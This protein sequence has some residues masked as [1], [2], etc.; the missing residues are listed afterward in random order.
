M[1]S[2]ASSRR[3]T[4][5]DA[6]VSIDVQ[7]L[8][9]GTQ[10]ANAFTG[11]DSP[12]TAVFSRTGYG[13][14]AKYITVVDEKTFIAKTKGV[15]RD[16]EITF[17][18][19]ICGAYLRWTA[20]GSAIFLE[21]NADTSSYALRI[22]SGV[23]EGRTQSGSDVG[24]GFTGIVKTFTTPAT[25]TISG[26]S[27]SSTSGHTW[28]LG[29]EGFE[30]YLKYNGTEFY[31]VTSLH[32]LT[33][34]KMAIGTH[35]DEATFGVRTVTA[36][37]KTNRTGLYSNIG[38]KIFDIRDF[39]MKAL[40]AT[41]SMTAASTTLTLVSN[42]G[43]AIGD[44]ICIA[45]GG[46][47]GGGIPGERGVGGQWPTLMYANAT[48]R[49][50]D[51]SQVTDKV[52]GLLDTGL[53]YQWN[54]SAWVVY[55][56]GIPR[57]HDKILPK[58]LVATITNVS[59]TNITLDTAAT[60]ST[61]SASVYFDN[62]VLFEDNLDST[63]SG[64][65]LQSGCTIS[66]PAGTWVFAGYTLV[67]GLTPNVRVTGADWDDTIILSP[68]G[69]V[70]TGILVSQCDNAY[71]G[72]M[73]FVG[74]TRTDKGFMFNY[75]ATTD[76]QDGQST[77]F[78]Q[79]LQGN[80]C[81]IEYIR[82]TN[83]SNAVSVIQYSDGS[84]QRFIDVIHETGHKQY[85]Q[86]AVN[87]ADSINCVSEDIT[88]DCPA[89]FKGLESFRSDGSILRRATGRNVIISSN[90]NTNIRIEDCSITYEAG[91]GDFNGNLDLPGGSQ[92]PSPN[93][94]LVNINANIGGESDVIVLENNDFIVE[95]RLWTG[96]GVSVIAI[97]GD[98]TSV[99][100]NGKYQDKPVTDPS[101]RF[102]LPDLGADI[103]SGGS[104]IV[105][106]SMAVVSDVSTV[107]FVVDGVRVESSSSW[108]A[109]GSSNGNLLRANHTV[110]NCVVDATNMP[111]TIS[112]TV[113]NN[114]T[115]AAYE[116]L[117]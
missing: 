99:V 63:E 61:T 3:R 78:V 34:G 62:A 88:F 24:P 70:E 114:I 49:D 101:G 31:R 116:A 25:G 97:I 42:P 106:R 74:N 30:I 94:P 8:T 5:V 47:A 75:N 95:G 39:G 18:G 33:P 55:A 92:N 109:F 20:G 73:A 23:T 113:S 2:S 76:Q 29:V 56:G 11:W 36:T 7:S 77:T 89:L 54:G 1:R 53:T 64:I 68:T 10:S 27:N 87:I 72:N 111:E 37:H 48:A 59:G 98:D 67:F 84:T 100:V 32:V 57:Y 12:A 71:V 115:N 19:S 41:G 6:P 81:E 80:T 38:D 82:G 40:T 83:Y 16:Q 110:Q 60:V 46:E 35:P 22:V 14:T 91:S 112:G 79:V 43:F 85:F 86:W 66:I 90:T 51:T 28:T 44:Q 103:A 65:R 9:V 26:Y 17:W 50:A 52:C 117:P 13:V 93:E 45:T 108:G 15:S 104:A 102:V 96:Y 4:R 107:T 21:V 58:A 69:I 105:N